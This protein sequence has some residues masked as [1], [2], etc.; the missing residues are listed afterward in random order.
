MYGGRVAG[1]CWQRKAGWTDNIRAPKS[2][3]LHELT[4]TRLDRDA[5]REF[6]SWTTT[7]RLMIESYR[8][9]KEIQKIV[10]SRV[11]LLPVY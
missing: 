4:T 9:R 1:S 5:W 6:V 3:S 8:K 11:K 2:S 7:G 10:H